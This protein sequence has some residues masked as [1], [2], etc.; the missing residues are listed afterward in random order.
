MTV[1]KLGGAWL[2]FEILRALSGAPVA[3]SGAPAQPSYSVEFGL[4]HEPPETAV[5]SY[6]ILT[7]CPAEA[8]KKNVVWRVTGLPR[9]RRQRRPH[10]GTR[11]TP[12]RAT[13]PAS[14]VV[15]DDGALG[16]RHRTQRARLAQ[17]D[18]ATAGRRPSSGS[19]SRRPLPVAQGDLWRTVCR[20]V[21]RPARRRGVG[22]RPSPGGGRA[23]PRGSPGST[24]LRTCLQELGAQQEH[25]RPHAMPAPDRR[26]GH[27]RCPVARQRRT[28]ARPE[29][30]SRL[31]SRR[32]RGSLGRGASRARCGAACRAWWRRSSP[33]W[34]SQMSPP[35]AQRTATRRGRHR[36]RHHVR[37]LGHAS[38]PALVGHGAA[39]GSDGAADAAAKQGFPPIRSSPTCVKPSSRYRIAEV[40][41]A[42][43]AVG[44]SQGLDDRLRRAGRRRAIARSTAWRGGWPCSGPRP[45]STRCP[46]PRFGKLLVVDRVEIESLRGL[47]RLIKG[48]ERNPRPLQAPVDRRVRRPR[49][50]Q[51]VRRQAD[52]QDGPRRQGAHPRVQ[53]LAVLR[54]G[55]AHRR[56]SPGARRG[57]RGH[58]AGRLL[59]R[60][61][62]AR[63]HV[64]AVP[65]GA[66]AG[67]QVPGGPGHAPDRQVRVRLRRRHELRLRQLLAARRGAPTRPAA[68][69][70]AASRRRVSR[71]SRS[72]SS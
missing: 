46:T 50:G 23:S 30:R 41:A 22:R 11:P 65:A 10:H 1:E 36:R 42:V 61:R 4:A 60:V 51:V 13:A 63:V 56:L 72:S 54:S 34:P 47:E 39:G 62:L 20:D 14:I 15:L 57:P 17:G 12:P 64:A 52:R 33:S 16:F 45:W 8:G 9:L 6:G 68:A 37:S 19:C 35:R 49:F 21:L 71:S 69:T 31:R 67:R 66:H 59:G 25:L 2:L 55:R 58:H 5:H 40:P 18:S 27:R 29:Y 38:P 70:D 32:P 7:P 24:P 48:Y 44:K 53:P 3:T 26:P 28:T 43:A